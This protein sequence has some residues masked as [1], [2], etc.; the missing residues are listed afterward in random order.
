MSTAGKLRNP[1]LPYDPASPEYH[2]VNTLI[3]SSTSDKSE[4]LAWLTNLSLL[5]KEDVFEIT[6]R[7]QMATTKLRY[8]VETIKDSLESI[9][10]LVLACYNQPA[11]SSKPLAADLASIDRGRSLHHPAAGSTFQPC[12]QT[13]YDRMQQYR[14]VAEPEATR[15]IQMFFII[16]GWETSVLVHEAYRVLDYEAI[17]M[18][19]R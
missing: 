19:N 5:S 16:L 2:L 1:I 12:F 14:H 10:Q 7:C 15:R 4:D 11:A 8:E 18:V 17:E 3:T 6:T 9:V 13:A